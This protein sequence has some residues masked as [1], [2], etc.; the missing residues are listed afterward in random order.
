M[1]CSASA[2]MRSISSLTRGNVVDQP[3]HHPAA[4]GAG[5]HVA[6]DHDLGIDARDLIVNVLD[7]EACALLALDL[8]QAVD[9]LV[10]QNPLGVAQRAHHQP[11][12]ELG[13]RD[14]RLLHV[15]MHRRFL[16]GDEARAHVHAGGAHRQRGDETARIR[17]AA[18]GDERNLQF[19][20]RARQ[21]DHVRHVVLAG[22]TAALEAID[23]DGVAA[24]LFR[25][26]RVPD[27]GAFV[28]HLDAGCLQRRHV[29]LGTAAGGLDDLDA[30]FPDRGDIFRIGRRGEAS[31]GR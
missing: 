20:R 31:A 13:G 30:A 25:L 1:I 10:L 6:V 26:Q 27:R 3:G 19:L 24:D 9:A 28:D 15:L 11:G 8:E 23:A 21:Q 2:M 18:R 22:M 16:G 12:V 7:L 14:Q 29:L 4:P 17:H 5:I